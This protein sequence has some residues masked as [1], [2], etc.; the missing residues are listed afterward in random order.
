MESNTPHCYNFSKSDRQDAQRTGPGNIIPGTATLK[1]GRRF[2]G[3]IGV[4]LS[5][6]EQAYRHSV[7]PGVPLFATQ[8]NP[9]P[10]IRRRHR[11]PSF[12]VRTCPLAL[13]PRKASYTDRA[14][15]LPTMLLPRPPIQQSTTVIF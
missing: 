2:L 5:E 1:V 9:Q 6:P 14:Q 3:A 13:R 11:A 7:G 12:L 10:R 4:I 15:E 8:Q